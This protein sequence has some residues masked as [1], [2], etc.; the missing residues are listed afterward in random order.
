MF[1]S[2][3]DLGGRLKELRKKRVLVLGGGLTAVQVAQLALKQHCKVTLLSR[4]P[5]TTRHFDVN[6]T[7]FDRRRAHLH[8]YE[9]LRE[10]L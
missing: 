8:H 6:E 3:E 2:D 9:R 7:W 10:P 1:H 4:R 5:L